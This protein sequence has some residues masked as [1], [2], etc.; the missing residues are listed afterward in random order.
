MRAISTSRRPRPAPRHAQRGATAVA[1]PTQALLAES[2]AQRVD[3]LA[4]HLPAA[5][6]GDGR[7]IHQARVATRA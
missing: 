4:A 3:A 5:L 2:L 1:T 7:G 6:A